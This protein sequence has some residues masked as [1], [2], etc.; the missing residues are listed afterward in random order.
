MTGMTTQFNFIIKKKDKIRV[1][2]QKTQEAILA[3]CIRKYYKVWIAVIY[4]QLLSISK[5]PQKQ[6][7]EDRQFMEEETN[8]EKTSEKMF[9]LP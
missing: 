3:A 6:K 5:N 7:G 2:R 4:K 1:K 9:D 8:S